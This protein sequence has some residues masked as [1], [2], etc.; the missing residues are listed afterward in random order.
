MAAK[1]DGNTIRT[2]RTRARILAESLRLFNERGEANVTTGTIAEA[3]DMSPGNLYY[4]F[5][6]KDEIVEQLFARFEER[7]DVQPA[8]PVGGAEAIEDLWLYLHLM[9]E[10]MRDYR[11]LYR[12]LD[13][14]TAR[15]RRLREHFNRIV[16]RKLVAVEALC[17][18]L[19]RVRAMRAT[20]AEIRTLARNVLVVA[21]YWLNF[22]ALRARGARRPAD[23]D[24]DLGEAAFQVMALIAPYL[25]GEARRHHERLGRTYID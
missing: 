17:A 20:P 19:V 6:N 21:T 8:A 14:L 3:L 18:E 1:A 10:G 4:H 5:R 13:D 12:N 23:E 9:L 11:F 25:V 24:P 2:E 16:D 22:Q 7:I 15:N